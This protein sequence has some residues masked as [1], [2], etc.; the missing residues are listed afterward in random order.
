MRRPLSGVLRSGTLAGV[1]GTTAMDLVWYAR[2]RAEGG[3][4]S[5]APWEFQQEINSFAEAPA[6]AKVGKVVARKANIDLPDSAAATTNNVVHWST[7]ITWGIVA[8]LFH[9]V[10]RIGAIKSGIVAGAAAFSTSYVVLPKLGVYK[11]ISEYDKKTLW[12]D[13]SAHLVFGSVVGLATAA[14][15]GVRAV[16][17]RFDS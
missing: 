12:K 9:R 2:Y 11:P 6:P 4:S 15:S 3:T 16:V 17:K 10:L 14:T 13:L 7:G 1:A 8:V 5:F